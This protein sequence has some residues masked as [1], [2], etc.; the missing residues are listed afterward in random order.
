MEVKREKAEVRKNSEKEKLLIDKNK[1]QISEEYITGNWHER[2]RRK[3][4][5][6]LISDSSHQ[7]CN[8]H[9][10][11]P[12]NDSLHQSITSYADVAWEGKST[13]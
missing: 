5:K 8:L 11:S 9:I 3:I 6:E 1:K 12:E 4:K 10:K 13:S 2:R 7:K